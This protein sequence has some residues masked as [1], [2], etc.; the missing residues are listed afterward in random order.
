LISITIR[1]NKP[2]AKIFRHRSE[3]EAEGGCGGNSAAPEPKRSERRRGGAVKVQSPDFVQRK[4]GFRSTNTTTVISL[5]VSIMIRL[6]HKNETI[7]MAQNKGKLNKRQ[8]EIIVII[9]RGG[10]LSISQIQEKISDKVSKITLNRDLKKILSLG[11]IESKGRGRS[12]TY[13]L[14]GH[15]NLI[16]SFNVEDYFRTETDKRSAK[17]RFNFGI[18]ALLKNIFM[19]E[20]KKYLQDLN[21][22]YQ[23][24]IKKLPEIILKKEFERLIIELSWKSSQIEGNTYTLLETEALIKENKEAMGHKKEEAIMILNHKITLDYIIKNKN[25]FKNISI[26]K[27]ENIHYLLTKNLGISRNVRKTAVGIVGTKYRPLDNK[28][29]IREALEKTCKVINEEKNIFA[30]ALLFSILIAYIQPFEDGN[31]RTSRLLGN[32]ILMAYDICPL[33]YRSVDETEYKKAV[34]IF[35]EQNNID[36][37]KKLFTE[38]FEFAVKNYFK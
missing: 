38:Q 36:Y 22:E 5:F 30:K 19:I 37:F 32:A 33:S 9:E 18:F 28:W 26:F 16:K 21:K 15:F 23:K 14:S 27:I 1:K 13:E 10:A 4:F 25:D 31:K 17:G 6:S 12:I 11:F 29:Q 35:Y 2:V 34:I 8:D 3:G 7:I 20:E 24:N